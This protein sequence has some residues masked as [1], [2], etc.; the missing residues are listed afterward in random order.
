MQ[1]YYA[2]TNGE[3]VAVVVVGSLVV[4]GFCVLCVLFVVAPF[5]F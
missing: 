5:L 1:P 3:R 2:L 4:G